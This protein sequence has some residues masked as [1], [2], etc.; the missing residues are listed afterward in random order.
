MN[1]TTKARPDSATPADFDAIVE[2]LAVLKRD[3]AALMGHVKSGAFNGASDAAETVIGE[4]G[5]RA[6]RLYEGVAAQGKRSAKAIGRQVDARPV[7][8]LLLAFG[9]GFIVS[10]LLNR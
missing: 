5:D 1:S 2:D 6:E 10:R 3:F 9:A 8:S 4:L 7:T